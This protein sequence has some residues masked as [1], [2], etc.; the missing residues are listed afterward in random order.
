[1][2]ITTTEEDFKA[3]EADYKKWYKSIT[4]Q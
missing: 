2:L 4:L 3:H 1:M